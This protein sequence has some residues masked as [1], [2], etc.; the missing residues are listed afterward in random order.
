[1]GTPVSSV[2]QAFAIMRVLAGDRALTLS[3]VA[4]ACGI[5]P[6]SCL[7]LLRTL[8]GEGVLH[9]H[10]GKRYALSP[11]WT[12][13]VAGENEAAAR[14]VALARP[15]LESAARKWLAPVGLW[16]VFGRDRLQLVALGEDVA[17]TR[18]HMEE[19]QRQPIGGGSVGRA[20]TAA[21]N[22]SEDEIRRR[23]SAVRWQRPVTEADY[24]LEIIEAAA[25]GY[26]IDDG[27]SYA[28]IA[29]LAAAVSGEPPEFCVS[30]SMFAGSRS[31]REVARIGGDLKALAE[32]LGTATGGRRS[33]STKAKIA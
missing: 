17:A 18:I 3:E 30:V 20:L 25:R 10:S 21:Q 29:S 26:A 24:R 15:L 27:L 32:Q 6:S 33:T 14:F 5:S 23:F 13:I 4:L 9:T 31:D 2:V 22:V 8:V 19:G 28:G 16:R 12:G 1:M 11:P 7:G